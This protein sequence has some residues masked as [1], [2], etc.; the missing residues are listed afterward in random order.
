VE[1]A[2]HPRV[3][4][5]VVVLTPQG[6]VLV[7]RKNPPFKGHWALPG[8][9]V[10][11]GEKVED[12]AVREVR[13]ETG[14]EISILALV[15]VY[16]D[17]D[18]DPRGHVI[19]IAFLGERMRGEIRAS[20]DAEEVRVFRRPPERMAFDHL[21]ILEDA[22]KRAKELGVKGLWEEKWGG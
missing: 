5:D 2:K 4:V 16:S 3:A 18:R 19:S 20:S 7:R 10:E 15:G 13:E 6:F 17:P 9:F 8:G 1:G 12:A 11:Y 22:L 14:L 21:R